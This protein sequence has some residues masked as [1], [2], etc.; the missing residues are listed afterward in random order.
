MDLS[1]S[2]QL[3]YFV[4]IILVKNLVSIHKFLLEEITRFYPQSSRIMRLIKRILYGNSTLLINFAVSAL[5]D[6]DNSILLMLLLPN[7]CGIVFEES[8]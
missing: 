3:L 1:K 2:E 4:N 7:I 6:S 5:V 8:K